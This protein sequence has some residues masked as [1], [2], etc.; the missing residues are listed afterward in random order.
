[1]KSRGFT[2]IEMATVLAI[3][4]TLAAV[5]TP[6]VMNFI[7]HA[8]T[9]RAIADVRGIANAVLL[10]QRDTGK[11]P[12]YSDVSSAG[13]DTS[14][15]TTLVGPGSSPGAAGS[16]AS[17]NTTTD[18]VLSLN[19]NLLCMSTTGPIG[20]VSYRGPYIANVDADPW[21][22]RYVVTASNLT[23]SSANWA[24]VISAGPNGT[25]ESNPSQTNTGSFLA[26]GDDIIAIIK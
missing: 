7:D 24:F 26:T 4:S 13:N 23:R 2:L 10:Y 11:F 8:R 9:T 21:G 20:R 5:L 18:L 3:I 17:F 6:T 12:I 14:A 19:Q 15:A 22:N 25:L 1:M 16:W